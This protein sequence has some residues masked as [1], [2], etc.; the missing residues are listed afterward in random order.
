M[1]QPSIEAFL[2]AHGQRP[3][4]PGIAEDLRPNSIADAYRLLHAVHDRLDAA[5][6]KRL[7][8]KVGSTSVAGQRIWGLSEPVYAGLFAADQSPDLGGGLRRP[9]ARPSVEIE[10]AAIIGRTIDGADPSMTPAIVADSIAACHVACE[11]ID[12]RYG[13]PLSLGVPALV[14]DDFFQAGWLLGPA[15]PDWRAQDLTAAEGFIEIDGDRKSG[16]ARS[17]LSAFE[18]LCWLARALARNG[19]VLRE[20]EVVLTGTLVPPVP[21]PP[22]ARAVS[23]GISGFATLVM[24]PS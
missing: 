2:A 12:N 17:I 7:G 10:I 5:G 6:N 11:I 18:S 14:A 20:G 23:M 1:T 21:L 4:W 15:N 16:S 19:R 9:L 3:A 8:W 13:E 24:A 22:G